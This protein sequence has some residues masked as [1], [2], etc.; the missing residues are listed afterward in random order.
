[1]YLSLSFEQTKAVNYRCII[2]SSNDNE[3]VPLVVNTSLSFPHSRPI[4]GFVTI[5][6]LVEQELLTLLEHLSS[7]PMLML[8]YMYVL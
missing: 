7:P 1:M 3:Y 4:S 2:T 5:L 6:T 8:F